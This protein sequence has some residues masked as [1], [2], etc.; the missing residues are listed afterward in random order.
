MLNKILLTMFLMFLT[1]SMFCMVPPMTP[2]PA[3]SHQAKIIS[4]DLHQITVIWPKIKE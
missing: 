1:F 2:P 4:P 3:K